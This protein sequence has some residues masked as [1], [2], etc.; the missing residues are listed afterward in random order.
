MLR[1]AAIA[2]NHW[3]MRGKDMQNET[4]NAAFNPPALKDTLLDAPR[5][6]WESSG[7]LRKKQ[8][9]RKSVRGDGHPVL[10][11]PGYGANDQLMKPLRRYLADIGYDPRPWNQGLNFRFT[12][13]TALDQINAFR[14]E[15]Q[16]KLATE[17]DHVFRQTGEKV[18]LVGW[19][20]GGVYAHS[21]GVRL[22]Q[23]VRRVVTLGA[24]FGDPRDTAAWNLL[25][26]IHRSDTD[27][28]SHDFTGW[29]NHGRE[30]E[31]AAQV[32]ESASP[33][34]VFVLYSEQDGIVSPGAARLNEANHI[35]HI[36]VKS[37]H[38]GFAYNPAVY[39]AI[40]DCLA[41]P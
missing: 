19:S 38:M 40:A 10:V 39:L 22:P 24:P 30:D 2:V 36:A 18:S 6:L 11:I 37:S 7:L 4:I 3:S 17:I 20:L 1:K 29:S 33:A 31:A 9:L 28:N 26:R 23:Q 14:A 41:S 16:D 25:K 32:S 15:M 12:R 27:D 8:L 35:R 34:P 21:L 5:A 13:I